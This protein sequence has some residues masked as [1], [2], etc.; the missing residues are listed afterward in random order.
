MNHEPKK[1]LGIGLILASGYFNW[2]LILSIVIGAYDIITGGGGG[3]DFAGDGLLHLAV[4]RII[5]G[6]S[7]LGSG[8]YILKWHKG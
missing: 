2:V 7:L 5:P 3:L 8:I 4:G 1:L 6:L